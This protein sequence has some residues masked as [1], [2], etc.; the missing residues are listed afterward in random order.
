MFTVIVIEQPQKGETLPLALGDCP[1][2]PVE[3]LRINFSKLT[4]AH[5]LAINRLAWKLPRKT[6]K[7]KG[8]PR[9][10]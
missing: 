2:E 3:H 7:D 9:K 10:R 8:C 1:V 6:R 5:I 4:P